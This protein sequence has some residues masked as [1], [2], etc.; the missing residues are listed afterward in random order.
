MPHKRY[1]VKQLTK[2]SPASSGNQRAGV[3]GGCDCAT[4]VLKEYAEARRWKVGG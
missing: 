1:A 4:A 2:R 3:V